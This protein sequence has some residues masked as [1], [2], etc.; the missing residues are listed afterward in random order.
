MGFVQHAY[1]ARAHASYV[2]C[3]TTRKST[4]RSSI[5]VYEMYRLH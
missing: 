3:S 5:I 1:S 2:L 4:F